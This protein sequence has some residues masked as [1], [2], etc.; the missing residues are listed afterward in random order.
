[1]CRAYHRAKC[2][3]IMN[4]ETNANALIA[5]REIRRHISNRR[6]NYN[7][8]DA[9]ITQALIG[10]TPLSMARNAGTIVLPCTSAVQR[11]SG[12]ISVALNALGNDE[13]NVYS[14]RS[15]ILENLSQHSERQAL[16]MR[17]CALVQMWAAQAAAED[18]HVTQRQLTMSSCTQPPLRYGSLGDF[19]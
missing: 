19:S 11:S 5:K 16:R 10:T 14:H 3:S 2:R 4:F 13:M 18:G 7:R 8:M 6:P 12:N 15:D 17:S 9:T 1:M